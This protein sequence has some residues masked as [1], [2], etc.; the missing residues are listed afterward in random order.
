LSSEGCKKLSIHSGGTGRL[1]LKAGLSRKKLLS[2]ES[3]ESLPDDENVGSREP[4]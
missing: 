4:S 2:G 3:G 1:P